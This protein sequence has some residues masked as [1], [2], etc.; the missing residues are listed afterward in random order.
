[1]PRRDAAMRLA[2]VGTLVVSALVGSGVAVAA[3][4]SFRPITLG[5]TMPDFTLP[6]LQGRDLQLSSL[7]GKN[8]VMVFPRVKY[9]DDVWCAICN[10]A[11]LE[12][13]T[14][15][16]KER[17][18]ETHNAEILVVVPFGAD[19]TSRWLEATSSL[20]P[21][22]NGWKH[23]QQPEKLDQGGREFVE[24]AKLLFP[25]D[26]SFEGSAVPRP[27]PIVL[28]ADREVTGGL[29]LF[30]T[31]WG[32]TKAE[33]QIPTV[34]ILDRKGVVRFKHMG[35]DTFDRPSARV[36][37]ETLRQVNGV[38]PS[39]SAEDKAGIEA[40]SL[41]YVEGWYRGDARRM[42]QAIH[43]DLAKRALRTQAG[44][45]ELWN[46]TRDDLVKNAH[47]TELKPGDRVD[48]SIL[49]VGDHIASA[50]IVSPRFVDHVQL[51]QLD[52]RWVIV[53][54]VWE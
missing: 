46:L 8:V 6:T 3:E 22:I 40:A 25:A 36:I 34:M 32:G 2:A 10:Y 49:E 9:K 1:M 35:Q 17:I 14:L 16:E 4:P 54:V 50:K 41:D 44:R 52:G 42:E 45:E 29:G 38:T 20:L 21:K 13:V 37:A 31:E 30:Q 24:R 27:F 11:Y 26:L 48:V 28:D 15:D 5:E 47:V 53:N 7:R 39:I 51:I 18:R 23:P 12:L 33:Q 19:V 43:P